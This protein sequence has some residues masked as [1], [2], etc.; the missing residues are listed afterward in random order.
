[1]THLLHTDVSA[2]PLADLP[3]EP[4]SVVAGAPKA[5]SAE[6]ADLG[7]LEI[8]VWEITAGT[9]TDVEVDEVMVVLSGR[10][11]VTF[12][13]DDSTSSSAGDGS[14]AAG[15]RAY[16]VGG[17]RNPPQ[18]LHL[19]LTHAHRWLRRNLPKCGTVNATVPRS[20]E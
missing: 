18:G 5:S 15:R 19:G 20:A 9:V 8:G 17:P 11:S 2:I 1:M 13:A 14:A 4:E 6:L 10:A 16:D 12:E 3:L 7:G